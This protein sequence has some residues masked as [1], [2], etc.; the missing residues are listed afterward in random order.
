M[1]GANHSFDPERLVRE[2]SAIVE[3]MDLEGWKA[4][5]ADNGVSIDTNG[6]A[7][8]PTGAVAS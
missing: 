2:A 3:R 5:F 8:R 4:L 7:R 6:N 1:A